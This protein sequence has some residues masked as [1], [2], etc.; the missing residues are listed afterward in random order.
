MPTLL[1]VHGGLWED[2]DAERF[3][4]RPGIVA[5]LEERG[6]DVLVPD[7]LRRA[8]SW[9]AEAAH[10]ASFLSGKP[11][12]VVAASFGCSAAVRLVVDYPGTAARLVLAWPASVRDPA[13]ASLAREH[14]AEQGASSSVI[15][16][17]LGSATLPSAGDSSLSSLTL[18][19]GILAAVPMTRFHPRSVVDA[20]LR[21][22]PSATE[23]PG[24]T[25]PPRPDF[26]PHLE[27]FL[28]AITGFASATAARPGAAPPNATPHGAAAPPGAAS[29]SESG[30]ARFDQNLFWSNPCL[31][32]TG[33]SA[34]AP[35]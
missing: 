12:T 24:C 7:R 28:D 13:A 4:R 34:G 33:S 25:E 8:P 9:E 19:A 2:M 15:G 21:L 5:G 17:L 11:V 23:L 35:H 20:L 22:L 32:E 10:L 6:F 30:K 31:P 26:T 29:E 27:G 18:P 3:W 14:L 1:L 16:A